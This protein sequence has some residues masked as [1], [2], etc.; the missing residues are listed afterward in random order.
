MN[1]TRQR[2]IGRFMWVLV[3][4]ALVSCGGDEP[5]V[6]PG[7]DIADA[8]NGAQDVPLEPSPDAAA[9]APGQDA[10]PTPDVPG[11][12]DAPVAAS[13]GD[14]LCDPDDEGCDS[15]PED[16]G[17]CDGCCVPHETSGCVDSQVADCVCDVDD[18]C[19]EHSWDAVCVSLVES[20]GC[21][22]CATPPCG[23]TV[24]DALGGEN[25]STCPADCGACCGDGWCQANQGET[26]HSCESDCGTCGDCCS[27]GLTGGC[28]DADV[29]ACVCDLDPFCC[30]N[31]WDVACVTKV[32]GAACGQC[33]CGD[34]ACDQEANEACDSCA[35]DCGACCGDGQ[36]VASHDEDC[37]T[38]E[39]DCGACCGDGICDDA[40]G[41]DCTTCA[42]DC[43]ACAEPPCEAGYHDGGDG[44]CVPE[45]TC[46][47]GYTPDGSGACVVD[48]G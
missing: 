25:C 21:G 12:P 7:G 31:L 16:C 17:P 33:H 14:D 4:L 46:T 30:Q 35:D 18:F 1:A 10:L 24:C 42:L 36:C 23:D 11:D 41:E 2:W 28:D 43:G 6:A 15:C 27:V 26:C 8:P 13:C 5:V 34:G 48:D 40:G 38:C 29:A 20:Q 9:D 45:G 47:D 39:S 22:T 19:C 37:S 32:E 44:E 3:T